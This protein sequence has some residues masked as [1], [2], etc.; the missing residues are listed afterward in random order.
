MPS[1]AEPAQGQV[2]DEIADEQRALEEDEGGRP[3]GARPTVSRQQRT[4]DQRL[5]EEGERGREKGDEDEA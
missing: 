5:D 2:R 4:R 1:N 3:D